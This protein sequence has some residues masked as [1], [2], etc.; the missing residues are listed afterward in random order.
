MTNV[1]PSTL[2]INSPGNF[3][4][5]RLRRNRQH[6]WLRRLVA[7]TTLSI[8]DLIQP[9]FVCGQS[10]PREIPSMPGIKRHSVTELVEYAATIEQKRI[11]AIAL[12][13]F[14]GP[15]QRLENVIELLRAE[16]LLCQAIQQVKHAA[17]E[18]GIIVD[19]ALDPYTTH[20]QDGIVRDGQVINDETVELISQYAVLLAQMG[21]DIIAPSEMMDGRVGAIR[22][23]LDG[24]RHQ[25]VGIMSYAAKYS[26]AFYGPFRDAVGSKTCLGQADKHTYQMD[27]ANTNEALREVALDLAEGADSVMV[28]PGMPY[29]DIV[30]RVKTEFGVPTFVYNVSGEYAMLKTAAKEGWLDYDACVL[31]MLLAFKRAGADG[32]LTYAA[33]DAADLLRKQG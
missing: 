3:P 1:A 12:F 5:V 7:E 11:P 6:K 8:D 24:A 25:D 18:L 21:A 28:K 22:Q 27:P 29:L 23:T 2:T 19:V 32:I 26:S 16:N 14:Y 15:A 30:H 17:P 10:D 4:Q 20:G 9:V 33:S 13:P 31:E